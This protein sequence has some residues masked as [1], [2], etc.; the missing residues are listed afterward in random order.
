MSKRKRKSIISIPVKDE[1]DVEKILQLELTNG[2]QLPF[3]TTNNRP[4]SWNEKVSDN[5]PLPDYFPITPQALTVLQKKSIQ[6]FVTKL[7]N[8]NIPIETTIFQRLEKLDLL[9]PQHEELKQKT[10]NSPLSKFTSDVSKRV[11]TSFLIML[12]SNH[13]SSIDELKDELKL[14]EDVDLDSQTVWF[15]MNY[16]ESCSNH[17]TQLGSF[18]LIRDLFSVLFKTHE[19][20]FYRYELTNDTLNSLRNI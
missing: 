11:I 5:P 7:Q 15:I 20:L 4:P 12:L 14:V 3:I 8:H 19:D 9:P 13:K 17:D 1:K 10:T 16:L 18:I 2:P 6:G